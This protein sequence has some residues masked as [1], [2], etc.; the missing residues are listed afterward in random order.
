[1][2]ASI[3]GALGTFGICLFC[4]IIIFAI[5]FGA[6]F[7]VLNRVAAPISCPGRDLQLSTENFYPRP[8]ET[9]TTITW[10]CVDQK[11]GVKLD[12]SWQTVLAAG[13]IDSF[14]LFAATMMYGVVT[15]LQKQ[16]AGK[17]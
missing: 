8:G 12:V 11:T 5:G 17:A 9:D 13:V 4:G 10:Y 6:A 1:M 3:T 14:I 7:P 2:K 16:V 15:S